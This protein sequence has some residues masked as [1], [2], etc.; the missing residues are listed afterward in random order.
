MATL[1][2]RKAKDGTVTWQ[3]VI[4]RTGYPTQAKT[5]P[6]K[7][8]AE[9]W[10]SDIE[11]DI[12]DRRIDPRALA[13]RKTLSAGITLYLEKEAPKMK[14]EK[15]VRRLCTWWSHKIGRITLSELNPVMVAE[16]LN[17]LSCSGPTKNRYLGALSGCLT[18][19]SKTP[20]S[21]PLPN[22]NPC[23]LVTR[24]AD[25]NNRKRIIKSNEWIRL[26]AYV[27][28]KATTGASRAKQLPTFMRLAYATGRR[29]S[30]LLRLTWACVDYDDECLHLLDTKSG[31]DNIVELDK[32]TKELLRAHEKEFRR[33]DSPYVFPGR[34][35]DKP[36]DFDEFIRAAIRATFEEDFRGEMPVFH[37][38]R[39][40]VATEMADGGATESEIMAVTGHKSSVSAHKYIKKTRE[41]A[42]SAQA[43]RK[44]G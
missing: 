25:G 34:F 18:T 21:W 2:K 19:L 12:R 28:K 32:A 15:D 27:D 5:F 14:S 7:Q 16:C 42:R 8:Q 30:E 1:K 20:Y 24:E 22:G 17:S 41:A 31:D 35:P 29:R 44:R 4:R 3:A 37:S 39:H 40:T 13:E 33:P 6:T 36:T 26:L 10:A 23:R 11:R 43:K 38:V 9:D